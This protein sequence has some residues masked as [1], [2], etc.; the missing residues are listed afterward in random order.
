MT[1]SSRRTIEA[2]LADRSE[3]CRLI[4]ADEERI[5]L[6][7]VGRPSSEHIESIGLRA[8]AGLNPFGRRMVFTWLKGEPRI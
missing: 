7:M 6:L 8:Y 3:Q 5:S 4:H 1:N 2:G